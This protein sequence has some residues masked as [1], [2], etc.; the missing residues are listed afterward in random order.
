MKKI[1]STLL[2]AGVSVALLIYLFKKI[3]VQVVWQL[4]SHA[5]L[6]YLLAAFGLYIL[7]QA[8]CAYRWKILA[9][10]MDFH[11]SLKE[12][13]VYYFAGM[14][15]NLFL[16]TVIG[17]DVGRCYYLARGRKKTFQ[18]VIS[19]LADRGT[20]L[21]AL[22]VIAGLSLYLLGKTDIP[23]PFFWGILIGNVL[24][25][26]GFFLP[27]FIGNFFSRFGK[28]FTLSLTYW[29]NPMPMVQSIALSFFFQMLVVLI[30][31]L[32]SLSLD[33]YIP[34]RFYFFLIPLVVLA[35]MLPVSLSG[36]GVREGAYVYFLSL[37]D[38]PTSTAMAFAL[39][40]LIIVV[41]ASLMGGLVILT[42][43]V[44]R[45]SKRGQIS[46]PLVGGD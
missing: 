25:I 44:D 28:A 4:L 33:L 31:I 16:P 27:F 17:G 35:S 3:D 46:S 32:I 2:K 36:L 19:I 23:S 13:V 7:G 39:A 29:R 5:Y 41:I 22:M 21:A 37:V 6:G 26:V 40:W 20:G 11:N 8:L 42:K 38:V 45:S 10:L 1:I 12:F 34:L 9:K 14:F 18:A 24:L 15:F 43:L 30:H